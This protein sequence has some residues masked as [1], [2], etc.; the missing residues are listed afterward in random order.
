MAQPALPEKITLSDGRSLSYCSFGDPAG[1]PLIAL[2]GT[3]GSR[4]KF[5]SADKAAHDLGLQ[6]ICPD[7]WGYAG[8]LAPNNISLSRY[9]RDIRELTDRLKIRRFAV[10]GVSGGGPFAAAIA[11]NLPDHVTRLGLFAPVGPVAGSRS[12]PGPTIPSSTFHR[13]CFRTLPKQPLVVRGIFEV[14]RAAL[15]VAPNS[16]IKIAAARAPKADRNIIYNKDNRKTLTMAFRIGLANGARGPQIDMTMFGEPWD[17][18]ISDVK[19]PTRLWLG[20]KDRNIPQSA[21][22]ALANQLPQCERIDIPNAG[23][24]WILQN[25]KEV[26]RWFCAE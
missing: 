5:A 11:A 15:S 7:R 20:A 16:A 6:L 13:F 14:Y 26:L 17:I 8:S 21:A 2:H 1:V 9:A 10:L 22:R 12:H 25:E 23:H 19:A 18:K 3:P 24:F 4:L